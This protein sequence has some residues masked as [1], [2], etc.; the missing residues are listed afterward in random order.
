MRHLLLLPPPP[1]PLLLL[2]LLLVVLLAVGGAPSTSPRWTSVSRS[3][4]CR[5]TYY[6]A[7]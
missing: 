1:L 3:E 6:S 5:L 4:P 2:L 7:E